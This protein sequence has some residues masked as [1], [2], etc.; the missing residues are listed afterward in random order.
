MRDP[1]FVELVV[2]ERDNGE[3]VGAYACFFESQ[4]DHG[5]SFAGCERVVECVAVL[6]TAHDNYEL[7][8]SF[9]DVLHSL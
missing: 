6:G 4:P 9:K 1:D 3:A 7:I 8:D 5:D 2:W